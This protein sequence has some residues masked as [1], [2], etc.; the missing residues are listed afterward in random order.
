MQNALQVFNFNDASPIRILLDESGEV[1]FVAK[2]IALA[3]GYSNTVDAVAKHCKKSKSLKDMGSAFRTPHINQGL[4]PQIKL[5]PEAD[6]YRLV[7][8]SKLDTAESF[9]DFMVEEVMPSIRKTGSYGTPPSPP[10]YA[11]TLRLYADSLEQMALDAPKVRL[12]N[13]L[14]EST[15]TRP[16]RNWVK[17]MK[18]DTGLKVGER[19]VFRWLLEHHYFYK[20]KSNCYMPCSKHES[21]GTNYFSLVVKEVDGKPRR[22]LQITG[23]GVLALTDKVVGHFSQSP[24]ALLPSG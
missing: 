9:Q 1:W 20:D 23:K 3:L 6:V 22:H 19:E 4:D 14:T 17:A 21:N 8:R 5:I 13:L 2:D 12:A 7:M 15:N 10:S 18:S 11:E 24:S 16:I